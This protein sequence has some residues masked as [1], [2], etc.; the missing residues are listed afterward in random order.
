VEGANFIL[1]HVEGARFDGAHVEGAI[2]GVAHLE[3]AD[4]QRAL[5]LTMEQFKYAKG[6]EQAHFDEAFRQELEAARG[7]D[8]SLG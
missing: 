2:F 1:A 5:G 8:G 7:K 6:W 3:R 4:F